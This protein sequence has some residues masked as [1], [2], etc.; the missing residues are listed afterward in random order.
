M[1]A[2]TATTKATT[3]ATSPSARAGV[4][5]AAVPVAAAIGVF[6]VVYGAAAGPVLGATMT[7]VSSLIIFSG[8][9][10]FTMIALVAAGATPVAV[11][12]AAAT[13][14]LRHLPLGA[15]LQPVLTGDRKRRAL[16]SPFLLDETVGLALASNERAD[17]T[18]VTSGG[19]AYVAFAAGTAVGVAG[20]SFASIEPLAAALFPVLFVGLAALTVGSRSDAARAVV[21]GGASVGL[22]L[23]W[24]AA[25]ALGVMGVA[26]VV[27]LLVRAE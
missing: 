26:V 6:G 20:R 15:V 2:T 14:A 16:I 11:L 22:L 12:G 9:A 25:G 1:T 13:L 4:L 19:L 21:A 8:V 10:Q 24:P 7:I 23:A 3:K 18:L 27:S 17:R 5:S